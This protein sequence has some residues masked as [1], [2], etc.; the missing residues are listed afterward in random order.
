MSESI[1]RS[2]IWDSGE[3]TLT[4]ATVDDRLIVFVGVLVFDFGPL[5]PVESLI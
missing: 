5:V 3:G 2:L 4:A 1:E